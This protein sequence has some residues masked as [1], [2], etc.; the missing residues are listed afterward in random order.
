LLL[1]QLVIKKPGYVYLYLSND[2]MALGGSQV[3]VYFDDFKVEHN[4]SPVVQTDDY[5]PFG[6]TFNSYKRESSVLNRIKFQSQ[7]HIDDLN[8]YW[9]SFKWRNH[10]PDIGRF[11]NVDPLAEKY[12]YNSPYAFSENKVTSHRELEGLEAESVNK[13]ETDR[14]KKETDKELQRR[15]E[16]KTPNLNVIPK[17]NTT[18]TSAKSNTTGGKFQS[19]DKKEESPGQQGR[20]PFTTD[21]PLDIVPFDYGG[22]AQSAEQN[23]FNGSTDIPAGGVVESATLNINIEVVEGGNP[24]TMTVQQGNFSMDGQGAQGPTLLNVNIQDVQGSF[25]TSIPLN[26]IN[27]NTNL[28][29]QFSGGGSNKVN[30]TG[31]IIIS[32]TKPKKP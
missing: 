3:E 24:Q 15:N 8:L 19:G 10:Q 20:E 14:Q 31:A 5:Y 4:K 28:S 30:V 17:E 11:F 18:N 1:K 12:L 7:E 21:R 23:I 13:K 2:N 16:G 32:G 22:G 26:N 29:V 9:D 25:N 27:P 6:L